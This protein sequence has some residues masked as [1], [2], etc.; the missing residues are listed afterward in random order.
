M[1]KGVAMLIFNEKQGHP[2]RIIPDETPGGIVAL[3][4]VR[5]E[6]ARSYVM[7]KRVLDVASGVGY[8]SDYLGASATSVLGIDID[9]RAAI[10][11]ARRYHGD[12]M[13]PLPG[14][15]RRASHCPPARTT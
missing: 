5:Y 8:G 10:A 12:R 13:S 3:H 6:F 1:I 15:M 14:A 7:G 4:L 11:Y 2:E 9:I